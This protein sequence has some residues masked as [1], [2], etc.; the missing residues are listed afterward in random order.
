MLMNYINGSLLP[1][2]EPL[3]SIKLIS[4]NCN[5][6]FT[7]FYSCTKQPSKT[8]EE[9]ACGNVLF[10]N[11][12]VLSLRAIL[13]FGNE[14]VGWREVRW[15][16]GWL[17][18]TMLRIARKSFTVMAEQTGTLSCKTNQLPFS[19]NCGVNSKYTSKTSRYVCLKF[20]VLTS[21]K[22]YL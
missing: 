4:L 20:T 13:T 10:D 22:N 19:R 7:P 11:I 21:G 1:L 9:N 2:K 16:C 3:N 12:V 17:I 14:K 5:T 6:H 8:A 18:S 15:I